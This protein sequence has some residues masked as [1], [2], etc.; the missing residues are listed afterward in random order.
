MLAYTALCPPL[1]CPHAHLRLVLPSPSRTP[2]CLLS[3]SCWLAAVPM[4]ERPSL[5]IGRV[6]TLGRLP[7]RVS[8]RACGLSG[9]AD[10]QG[11]HG[12]PQR[13]VRRKHPVIP[14]PVLARRRHEVRKATQKLVRREVDDALRIR[15]RRLLVAAG[16]DPLPALVPRKGVADSLRA[17][18]EGDPH[19]KRRW[20][21]HC[22]P[23]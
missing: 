14:V 3:P 10:R 15:S 8:R 17:V 12:C 6:G 21:T 1:P 2:L 23:T 20:K 22:A 13:M 5:S 9:V 16:P 7:L 18:V 19:A 11:S 4:M